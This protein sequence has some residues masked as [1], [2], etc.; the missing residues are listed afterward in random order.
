MPVPVSLAEIEAPRGDQREQVAEVL[1]TSLNSS[2]ERP[3][4]RSHLYPIDDMRV[5]PFF[6]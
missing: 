1:A 5:C 4:A 3:A 6:F 2:P